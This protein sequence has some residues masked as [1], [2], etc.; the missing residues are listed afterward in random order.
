ME[1]SLSSA[2]IVF[3]STSANCENNAC[4][5]IMFIQSFVLNCQNQVNNSLF[6]DDTTKQSY[7]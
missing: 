2:F 1:E 7:E 6:N 5:I 3:R 4:T